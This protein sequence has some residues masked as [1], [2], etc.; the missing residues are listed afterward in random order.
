MS[1]N[2]ATWAKVLAN[3]IVTIACCVLTCSVS[4]AVGRFV[5]TVAQ[6]AE[7][8]VTQQ[9]TLLLRNLLKTLISPEM[10]GQMLKQMG[11]K[12]GIFMATSYFSMGNGFVNLGEFVYAACRGKANESEEE[13]A[14][15]DKAFESLEI[16]F[17]VL[18]ALMVAFAAYRGLSS[19]GESAEGEKSIAELLGKELGG[20]RSQI[21][22]IAQCLQGAA[23]GASMV[24]NTGSAINFGEQ[25]GL[26]VELGDTQAKITVTQMV[27]EMNKMLSGKE[28]E[29]FAA[30]ILEEVR[31]LLAVLRAMSEGELEAGKVL[32]ETAV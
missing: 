19:L 15:D 22:M 4:S 17:A 21:L 10:W 25:A 29:N 20:R 26:Q 31:A 12:Q 13:L 28:L 1:K 7:M 9:V 11:S 24:A 5:T 6:E 16:V 14:K 8:T 2:N 30:E 18:Q 23:N 32:V 27:E 3:V